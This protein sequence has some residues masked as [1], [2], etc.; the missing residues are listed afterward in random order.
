VD[1]DDRRTALAGDSMMDQRQCYP[2]HGKPVR[3]SIGRAKSGQ[4]PATV[5]PSN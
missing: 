3:S 1:E 5:L 2:L 4:S